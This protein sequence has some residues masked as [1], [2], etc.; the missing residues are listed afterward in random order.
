M[1]KNILIVLF[2]YFNFMSMA[3][4]DMPSFPKCTVTDG[5]TAAPASSAFCSTEPDLY[6]L[7]IYEMKLCTSAFT[8]PTTSA[9]AVTSS[10]QAVLTN[11]SPS[12]M[13]ITKGA[14]SPV[15]GT[16][17]RPPNG[18]YTHGYILLSNVLSVTDSRQFN[19]SFDDDDAAY[20]ADGVYCAST[21]TGADCDSSA[22]T[23]IEQPMALGATHMT[24]YTAG[25]QAIAGYG[26]MNAW[27]V[28]TDQKLEADTD[29]D[30]KYMVGELA[31]TTPVVLTDSTTSMNMS[32][33]V[34]N[35]IMFMNQN[36]GGVP[37]LGIYAGPF[38]IRMSVE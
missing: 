30:V 19:T 20:V 9:A 10:C 5:V 4:A 17:T 13:I 22:V 25:E 16:I 8:P 2:V 7:T 23:A 32:F 33:D 21:A 29:A 36:R 1:K 38:M 31:F 18:T 3:Y 28:D 37:G 35:G 15:S 14:A 24:N 11:A 27:L 6:K 12:A 34:S 26:T